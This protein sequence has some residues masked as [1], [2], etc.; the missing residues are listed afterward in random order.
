MITFTE[1]LAALLQT[2]FEGRGMTLPVLCNADGL[3]S[4]PQFCLLTL[5]TADERV[6]FNRTYQLSYTLEAG[7]RLPLF[8][9]ET[10]PSFENWSATVNT[11]AQEALSSLSKYQP[12]PGQPVGAPMVLQ[13]W[14]GT[15]QAQASDAGY[16]AQ[17]DINMVVQF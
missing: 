1:N 16:T 9:E 7:L 10:P 15:P 2:Y 12:L 8:A 13:C 4:L 11:T 3:N 17:L 6:D 14:L 5:S